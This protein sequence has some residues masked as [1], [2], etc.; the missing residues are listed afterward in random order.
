MVRTDHRCHGCGK[1]SDTV[2]CAECAKNQKCPH[3]KKIGECDRCDTESDL[4]YD[5]ARETGRIR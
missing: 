2:Y 1:P 3:G 4:A 5:A